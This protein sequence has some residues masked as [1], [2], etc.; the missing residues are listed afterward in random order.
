M[1]LTDRDIRQRDLIPP[2]KME[3]VQ[4]TVVGTGAIG[5][6]V[7]IALATLGVPELQLVD[8][9]LVEV[10]NLGA[11]GFLEADLHGPKSHAVAG[12][13]RKINSSINVESDNRKW[14]PGHL[15]NP[16]VFCCV[17]TMEVRKQLWD[18]IGDHCT[19][20]VDG[21]MNSEVLSVFTVFDDK[22]R[23]YYP[24]RLYTDEQA[25]E[26][27]CTSRTTFYTSMT[28]AGYM[29]SMFTKFLRGDH[30]VIPYELLVNLQVSESYILKG[31]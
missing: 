8:F 6:Q 18:T 21:R 11:Q 1:D 28:A 24:T 16:Y 10:E 31:S 19:F 23:E 4:A 25:T 22:S 26:G 14:K 7:A 20:M 5:R 15:L 9:D 3:F 2:K 27:S 13:C 30:L 29:V 12:L 17:D